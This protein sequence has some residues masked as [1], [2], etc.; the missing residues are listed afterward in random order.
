[1]ESV[2]GELDISTPSTVNFDI[3][4][5][6]HTE[7]MKHSASI[8]NIGHYGNGIDMIGLEKFEG[9]KVENI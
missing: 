1:M 7:K 5:V 8:G 6:E 2:V 3:I 4:I 9:I